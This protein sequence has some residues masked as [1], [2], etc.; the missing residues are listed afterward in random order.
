M[1]L[2]L[3][4]FSAAGLKN[5]INQSFYNLISEKG[6]ESIINRIQKKIKIWDFISILCAYIGM[7]SSIIGAENNVSFI[8]P[9]EG[10]DI[11][12]VTIIYNPTQ[13]IVT[14]NRFIVSFT[15]FILLICLIIRYRYYL[16]LEKY[17][18]NIKFDET[19]FSTGLW[20]FLLIE[21]V[22]NMV[23]TPPYIDA[24]VEVYPMSGNLPAKLNIDFIFTIFL[25][26]ARFYHYLKFIGIHSE[27][28]CHRV[29][30]IC[31]KCKTPV[32]FLFCLKS[33]FK[34][35]PFTLVLVTWA[36]A[37]FVF[38]YALRGIEM[39]FMPGGNGLDWSYFWNGMWCMVI[40]MATV[41]FG[42]YYPISI[43]GRILVVIC[44][45]L[46]TFLVSLLVSALSL[47][48]EFNP[49]EQNAYDSINEVNFEFEYGE[50]AVIVLQ[51]ALRYHWHVKSATDDYFERDINFRRTKSQLYILIRDI[52]Q[53]FRKLK[54]KKEDTT[55]SIKIYQS[56]NKIEAY[57]SVELVKIKEQL[58][59]LEIVRKMLEEFLNNQMIIKDKAY[60]LYRKVENIHN[61]KEEIKSNYNLA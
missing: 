7:L 55:N 11:E 6:R 37:I 54:R 3:N 4:I 46:G 1:K 51:R 14:V 19:L 13:T 9:K 29:E 25:I 21:I 34:N 35:K 42:D 44:G 60:N 30:K 2:K 38:G 15:T 40:T 43:L 24:Y 56:L 16:I 58:S 23:H 28:S 10:R 49:Q 31:L 47:T 33:E 53:S 17:K 12:K 5:E 57:I 41:G 27:W 48:V 20:K 52:L 59:T 18:I 8:F 61:L 36:F 45:F 26:I 39:I 32:N 22:L 50:T